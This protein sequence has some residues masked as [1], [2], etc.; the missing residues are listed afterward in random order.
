MGSTMNRTLLLPA[1]LLLATPGTALAQADAQTAS[2]SRRLREAETPEQRAHA[3]QLLGDSEDPEAVPAL[4]AA[5]EDPDAPVRA[6]AAHALRK[7]E[8]LEALEC[9]RA[10]KKDPDEQ[11]QGA[12]KQALG[13]LE[14]LAA[15]PAKVYVLFE[16]V[17]DTTGTLSPE[18]V[19]S[20]NARIRRRLVQ[21]GAQLAPE[22]EEEAAAK[23]VLRKR[24]LKGFRMKVEV[25]PGAE[26]GLKL[27]LLCL[28][29][30]GKQ[31][32]GTVNVQASG[33]EPPE[34]LKVLAPAIVNEAVDTFA[35][36]K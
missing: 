35:W 34:L 6:A 17:E 5:L 14:K 3:A 27:A 36:G 8:Q 9:L 11:V 16:G 32:Q 28:R 26:G 19:R 2:F 30:P 20:T 25:R 33:D 31:L 1:V 21:V 23:E 18:W 29:Y 7:L 22:Q 15:R 4:C 12:L 24:K 10:R 13:A